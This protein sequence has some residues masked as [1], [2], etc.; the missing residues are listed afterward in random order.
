MR[1]GEK[2]LGCEAAYSLR[3]AVTGFTRAARVAGINV[4]ADA[5]TSTTPAMT[6]PT[7]TRLGDLSTVPVRHARAERHANTDLAPTLPHAQCDGAVE[8]NG[9]QQQHQPA[10]RDNAGLKRLHAPRLRGLDLRERE[11]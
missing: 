6:P 9:R 4:A 1:E 11:Q 10:T 8:S 7:S 5:T 3:S 2:P